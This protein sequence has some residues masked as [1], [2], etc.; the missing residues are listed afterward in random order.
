[1]ANPLMR[2]AR[3][4][5]E[6]EDN[7]DAA[8]AAAAVAALNNVRGTAGRRGA[9]ADAT[10]KHLGVREV[11]EAAA[12]LSSAFV[13]VEATVSTAKLVPKETAG[14]RL[15][16]TVP[17]SLAPRPHPARIPHYVLPSP[18]WPLA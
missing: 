2:G 11:E 7:N 1:M 15:Y 8:A 18:R 13:E 9:A 14:G 6:G 5:A 17:A 4:P 16:K 10:R 3:N 12:P